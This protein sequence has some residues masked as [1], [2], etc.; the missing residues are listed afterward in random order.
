[1][2]FLLFLAFLGLSLICHIF[3]AETYLGV[4]AGAHYNAF[5]AK[6]Q[7][8][9]PSTLEVMSKSNPLAPL[10]SLFGGFGKQHDNFYIGADLSLFSDLS[11]S[12]VRIAYNQFHE[13][14]YPFSQNVRPALQ[15]GSWVTKNWKPY[16]LIG[17][18]ILREK[19]SQTMCF[20]D[21][22]DSQSQ[23]KTSIAAVLGGG[24]EHRF[25]EFW[26]LR[27]GYELQIRRAQKLNMSRFLAITIGQRL[28]Q[29]LTLGVA[30]LF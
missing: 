18:A 26:K 30:Y 12:K 22:Y 28:D 16:A 9:G 10:I 23:T 14:L 2:K 25:S 20:E 5:E 8:V 3:A 21:S 17:F 1:M 7:P 13:A 24:V 6:G 19:I 4:Q 27:L 11:S 29:Q 15:I